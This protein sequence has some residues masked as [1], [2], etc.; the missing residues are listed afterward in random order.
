MAGSRP[1]AVA[2]GLTLIKFCGMTRA[3]DANRAAQLGAAHVGVIFAESPR[4]VDEATARLVFEAAGEQVGHVAVFGRASVDDIAAKAT[5]AGADTVQLHG[6]QDASSVADLRKRFR[7]KIW[8][9]VSLDADSDSL[10]REATELA[11]AA[12]ALLLDARVGGRS[13][14]T[15]RTLRWDR[16]AESI[17]RLRDRTELV[18]AGGLSAENVAAAIRAIRPHI[19]DVSSGVE[20]SPGIKDFVRMEA[21]AEAVRSA[22]II[23]GEGT[24]TASEGK[25]IRPSRLESE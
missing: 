13:G 15:G 8:A 1:D 12:D 14:G 5:R 25:T 16:L 2:P 10:P 21:F 11:S 20:S 17:G 22:S 4:Q 23:V 9:V 18:L 24:Y 6:A 3:A 19:V 7:G